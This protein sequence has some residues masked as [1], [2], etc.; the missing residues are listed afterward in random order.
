MTSSE[1][2]RGSLSRGQTCQLVQSRTW[3]T[4]S[5]RLKSISEDLPLFRALATPWSKEKVRSQWISYTRA[6]ELVKD[7]FRDITDVSK[8]S[9]HSLRAGRATSAVNAGIADRLFKRHGRSIPA[10]QSRSL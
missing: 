3:R 10:C 8:S 5:R 1:R 2:E 4:T 6:R 7:A 9:V